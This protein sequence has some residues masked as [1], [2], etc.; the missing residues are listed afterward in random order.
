MQQVVLSYTVVVLQAPT[1]VDY[2]LWLHYWSITFIKC[3]LE[4]TEL[5]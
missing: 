1:S 2:I 4:R 3:L 5:L